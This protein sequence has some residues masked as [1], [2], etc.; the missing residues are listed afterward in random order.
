MNADHYC[1]LRILDDSFKRFAT[2]APLNA[3]GFC[4]L[5][6]LH[7]LAQ[8]G[9]FPSENAQTGTFSFHEVEVVRVKRKRVGDSHVEFSC[10]KMLRKRNLHSVM[11]CEL[12]QAKA[13]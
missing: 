3:R 13:L 10:D 6:N 8:G 11:R 5:E 2:V 4:K 12:L 9:F 7:V 1:L